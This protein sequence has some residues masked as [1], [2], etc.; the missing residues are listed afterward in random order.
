MRPHALAAIALAAVALGACGGSDE[1]RTVGPLKWEGAPDVFTPETLPHDRILTGRIR[2]GSPRRV[3]LVAGKVRLVDGDGDTVKGSAVFSQTYGHGLFP[4]TRE[5]RAVSDFERRRTGAIAQIQP[6]R[7]VP[8]TIAWR[9]SKGVDPPVRIEY[10]GG[11][12]A[13]PQP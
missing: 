2:N 1:A 6:G 8:F 11:S 10:G 12:L 5:P 3:D 9:L 7:A 4:P 13:I